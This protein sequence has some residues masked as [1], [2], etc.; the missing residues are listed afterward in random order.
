VSRNKII[1]TL[2]FLALV[3]AAAAGYALLPKRYRVG[4]RLNQTN[5]FSE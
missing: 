5:V 3:A 4:Q 2:I 1:S